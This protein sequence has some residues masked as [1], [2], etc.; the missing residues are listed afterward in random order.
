MIAVARDAED[1]GFESFYVPEHIALN[2]GAAVGV[3]VFPSAT[4]I[5]HPLECLSFVAA[6]TQRILLGTGV[7]LLPLPPPGGAGR[8]A[9]HARPA[10][11]GLARDRGGLGLQR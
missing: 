9:G 5:A 8:A 6:A 11:Q 10:V 7:L 4:P 3:A 2:P 1:C